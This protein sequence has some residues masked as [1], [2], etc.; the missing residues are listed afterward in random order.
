MEV[1][2]ILS[3]ISSAADVAVALL[4]Y[5][6]GFV[7]DTYIFP[8]GHP[9]GTV[10]AVTAIGA[11]GAKNAVVALIEALK[12]GRKFEGDPAEL[13]R[14]A[15]DLM[16]YMEQLIQK[17]E[18]DETHPIQTAH[19]ALGNARALARVGIIDNDGFH[20]LILEAAEIC[21]RHLP[22]RRNLRAGILS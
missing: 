6:A 14:R 8:G 16:I 2:D 17:G 18:F 20:Q 4:G 21:R 19:D 5:A 12:K 7:A 11:T 10:A 15:N 1:K 13:D 3:K 22:S 9:P